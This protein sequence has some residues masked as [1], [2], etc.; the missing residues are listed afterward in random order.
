MRAEDLPLRR[1]V[2]SFAFIAT[3]YFFYAWS[4]NTVDIL[5]PYIAADL[6]LSLQA[7][8]YIYTAQSL[9]A[10]IG[11]IVNAQLADRFGRRNALFVVMV[12]FG[13]SLASGALVT[14]YEQVLTQRFVLGYFT[15]SMFPIAVGLYPGLFEQRRRGLLAGLLL[16]SYNLAQIAQGEAGR[17]FLDRDWKIL[18]WVGLIPVAIAPLAFLFVPNDRKV[19]PW[20]G[21]SKGV[22]QKLPFTELFQKRY[23]VQTLLVISMTGLNFF[24]YQAFAGWHTTYLKDTL[25]L[26]G[27]AIGKLV[28]ATFL[29][30]LIGSLSWGM[31][32][33][34]LGRRTNAFSFFVA[35]GIICLY[36]AIPMEV[37]T[38]WFAIFAYGFFVSASVIW[39]PW[40]AEL[41]PTHLRSTAA[42]LFNYGRIISFAAPPL[43]AALSA[44]IGLPGTMALGAPIFIMAALVWLRLPETLEKRGTA[45]APAQ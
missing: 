34:R 16:C 3:A 12:A 44:N 31:I 41:Y 14:S 40:L 43:T 42:S 23:R 19:V 38:R 30:G 18:L 26:S 32:A 27:D 25:G 33:D 11:A 35:A 21:A 20:G 6:K 39:G 8:S 15:G 10:L 29:G 4:F 2:A 5:R 17:Y 13:L 22:L 24:A 45:T 36:L 9:G 37:G 7:V 28:S 1:R